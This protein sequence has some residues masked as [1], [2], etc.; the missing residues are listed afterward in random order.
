MQISFIFTGKQQPKAV[1]YMLFDVNTVKYY[2]G[3][4]L[5]SYILGML[6]YILAIMWSSS[7]KQIL[8]IIWYNLLSSLIMWT[9]LYPLWCNLASSHGPQMIR[10]I[11]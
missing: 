4:C 7:D 6:I 2:P 11:T 1:W 9:N 10:L 3:L 5:K 8:H